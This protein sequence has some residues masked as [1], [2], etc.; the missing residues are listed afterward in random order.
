MIQHNDFSKGS[1]E[2]NIKKYMQVIRLCVCVCG[3]G[4]E[5][6]HEFLNQVLH[7]F[8]REDVILQNYASVCVCMCMDACMCVCDCDVHVY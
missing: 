4:G 5:Q 7:F 2:P 1:S 3:D 6:P 8:V